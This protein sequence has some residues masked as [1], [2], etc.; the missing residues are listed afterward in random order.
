[1]Q[2][3]KKEIELQEQVLQG[4]L[5]L[6]RFQDIQTV[7]QFDYQSPYQQFNRSKVLGKL[8]ALFRVR[9]PDKYCLALQT[10]AGIGRLTNVVVME[11]SV[12][13]DL[14][15]GRV[16]PHRV[17][18]MPLKEI[19]MSKLPRAE[20][21]KIEQLTSGKAKLALDLIEYDATLEAAMEQVFGK[22]FICDD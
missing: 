5:S 15:N 19:Q 12:A 3:L 17:T 14:I 21:S 1:M 6:E 13:K 2:K 8:A 7:V 10:A 20:V 22:I 9:E 16:L 18:F 11:S 4:G